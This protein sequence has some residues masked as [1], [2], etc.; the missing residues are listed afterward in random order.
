MD[1]NYSAAQSL[2]GNANKGKAAAGPDQMAQQGSMAAA[3]PINDATGGATFSNGQWTMNP[4]GSGTGAVPNP[5]GGNA[6]GGQSVLNGGNNGLGYTPSYYD[7]VTA[8]TPGSGMGQ[9]SINNTRFN[10]FA[11]QGT[12]DNLQAILK[13]LGFDSTQTDTAF[14]GGPA[15]S[16]PQHNL[17]INGNLMN[18]GLIQQRLDNNKNPDGSYNLDYFKKQMQDEINSNGIGGSRQTE[19]AAGNPGYGMGGTVALTNNG[20]NYDNGQMGG[21]AANRDGNATQAQQAQLNPNAGQNFNASLAGGGQQSPSGSM[22]GMGMAGA[23]SS[24]GNA[25]PWNQFNGYGAG[26]GAYGG[27]GQSSYGGMPQR[28][29]SF[30]GGGGIMN[31]SWYPQSEPNMRP[32][33]TGNFQN[34]GQAPLMAQQAM[35]QPYSSYGSYGGGSPASM[36]SGMAGAR[37]PQTQ[38]YYGNANPGGSYNG[39]PA[40]Y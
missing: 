38:P 8:E 29:P 31:S 4:A 39:Y 7:N 40:M 18:S 30:G 3:R 9:Q 21:Y 12:S 28:R 34:Q 17:N 5:G 11:D 24:Y 19:D 25:N 27:G 37:R 2:F 20:I 32:G 33:M 36:S 1:D 26:G 10:Q 22:S 35:R 15:P 13:K 16:S 14:G 23:P 6:G